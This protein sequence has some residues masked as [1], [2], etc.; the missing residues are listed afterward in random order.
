MRDISDHQGNEK[1]ETTMRY[2]L[3]LIWMAIKN[4]QTKQKKNDNKTGIGKN[5]DELGPLCVAGR[6]NVKWCSSYRK[7]YRL[8]KKSNSLKN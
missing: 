1:K 2:C 5:E 6:N 3:T 4:K 7:Q 8:S